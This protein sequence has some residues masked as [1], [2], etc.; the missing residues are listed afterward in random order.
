[1]NYFL[2]DAF[3]VTKAE[4]N[5]IIKAIEGTEPDKEVCEKASED[6]LKF[7]KTELFY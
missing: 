1:M 5:D 4:K 7:W 2:D 6:K 3:N